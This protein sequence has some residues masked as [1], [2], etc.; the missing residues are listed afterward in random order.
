MTPDEA[1]KMIEDVLA[2]IAPG[3]E[4][5]Q[6][7]ADSD[8]RESLELDSLDFLNF[9]EAL[10]DRAGRRIDE[11]DYPRLATIGTG[12]TFLTEEE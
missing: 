6:L 7:D 12:V 8:L 10:S 2:E 4:V 3:T 9:V 11:D 5:A 1:Q